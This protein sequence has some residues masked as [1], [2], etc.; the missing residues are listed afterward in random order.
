MKWNIKHQIKKVQINWIK[1]CWEWNKS[2][3]ICTFC[4]SLC[5]ILLSSFFLSW[6]SRK[7]SRSA[8]WRWWSTSFLNSYLLSWFFP[9]IQLFMGFW[10]FLNKWWDKSLVIIEDGVSRILGQVGNVE[11]FKNVIVHILIQ[12]IR[13]EFL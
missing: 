11:S 1:K 4:L 12:S 9:N 10:S 8:M 7:A 13:P 6:K 2:G 5:I 3:W